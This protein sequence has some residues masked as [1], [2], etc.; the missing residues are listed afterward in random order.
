MTRAAEAEGAPRDG[1]LLEAGDQI[2]QVAGCLP[3]IAGY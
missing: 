2:E 3:Y 1:V